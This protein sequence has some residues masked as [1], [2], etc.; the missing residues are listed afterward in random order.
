MADDTTRYDPAT[1]A[2]K[3]VVGA[4]L[5]AAIQA[6]KNHLASVATSGAYS[7]LSG[8]PSLAAVATSGS[9]SD[10][11]NRPSLAA[12][13]TSGAYS[14]LS[15]T[16]A[17]ANVATS[18]AYSDLS[19]TPNLASVATS[20][21]Y[22]DLSGTPDLSVYVLQTALN[23]IVSDIE[24]EMARLL[25]D[26]NNVRPGRRIRD[27][28]E[29]ADEVA[30]Y[31]S[32]YMF[33]HARVQ[34]QDWSNLRIGDYFEVPNTS[35]GAKMNAIFAFDHYYNCADTAI[36]HHLVCGPIEAISIASGSTYNVNSGH[37]QWNTTNNNNGSAAN[38]NPYI[39]SNLHAWELNEYLPG[40]PSDLQGIL[41][42]HRALVEDRYN[43]G[44]TLTDS[45]GWHWD[46]L[47]KVWSPGEVEVYGYVAW[48]TPEWSQGME[49]QFPFFQETKNRIYTDNGYSGGTRRGWWLRVARSASSAYACRVGNGGN[50][51]TNDTSHTNIRPRPCF[52]L[53]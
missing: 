39:V 13:A 47:G 7:D 52:L 3:P 30:T 2:D 36:G 4:T 45:T 41:L 10:L 42:N 40:L 9:Y 28:P 24:A 48:G 50:A 20:G 22:S 32:E 35:V 17:L 14:D 34:A 15:G 18:G 26:V 38:K 19:G 25:Q 49:S 53:G 11:Q 27:I 16:P 21:A 1:D 46:D 44:S 8:A 29:I 12:V 5:A 31:S 33:L 43:S 37:I 6:V 23:T 51:D